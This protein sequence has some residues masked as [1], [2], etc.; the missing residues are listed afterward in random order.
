ML[1]PAFSRRPES[2]S[3]TSGLRPTSWTGHGVTASRLL[4]TSS[5]VSSAFS[6]LR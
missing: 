5:S 1:E 3:K 6:A 4:S 2:S